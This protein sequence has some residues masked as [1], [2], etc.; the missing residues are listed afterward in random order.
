MPSPHAPSRP[1][2][3]PPRPNRLRGCLTAAALALAAFAAAPASGQA[4]PRSII[5]ATNVG[6]S[7]GVIQTFVQ[8]Q[9][10]RLGG[11]DLQESARAR[12]A[13]IAPV[14]GDAASGSFLQT[15][16]EDI[17]SALLPLTKADDARVRLNVV[18]V[19]YRVARASGSADLAALVTA[20]VNDPSAGVSMWGIRAAGAVLPT[21]MN[22]PML[23]GQD[24]IAPSIL[25][26]V[27][28]FPESGPV[29]E[30]AYASLSMNLKDGSAIAKLPQGVFPQVLPIAV[31]NVQQV[32]ALRLG[33][34]GPGKQPA[35]PGADQQ[36]ANFLL[37][38]RVWP[39]LGAPRQNRTVLLMANL[40]RAAVGAIGVPGGD[41]EG[42]RSMLGTIGS[43]FTTVGKVQGSNPLTAAGVGVSGIGRSTTPE[44]A[45]T[46][47]QNMIEV[48][49]QLFPDAMTPPPA[50]APTSAPGGA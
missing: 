37:D 40:M 25:T 39:N 36:A 14:L 48:L 4:L 38:S 41:D 23:R 26:A 49:G 28:R 46:S 7:A 9:A 42:V 10:Q 24:Q 45:A 35:A 13:L 29:A 20:L 18:L 3:R 27:K 34:Y 21:I 32:L 8:Q 31:D 33:Q 11:A 15:Y 1:S 6:E 47:V 43:G 19:A 2:A 50:P 30:E 12:E 16:A 22:N 5:S 44:Q 17:S